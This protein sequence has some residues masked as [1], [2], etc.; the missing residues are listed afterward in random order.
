MATRERGGQPASGIEVVL[1]NSIEGWARFF[2]FFVFIFHRSSL[3]LSLPFFSTHN[4]FFF[5]FSPWYKLAGM[6]KCVNSRQKWIIGRVGGERTVRSS[7]K[8]KFPIRSLSI[9][10]KLKW[11]TFFIIYLDTLYEFGR[12]RIEGRVETRT[13]SCGVNYVDIFGSLS[14]SHVSSSNR[15]IPAHEPEYN[16]RR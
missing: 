1:S 4:V 13:D 15:Q 5:P 12:R 3:F 16:V 10:P 8:P 11:D 6:E 2:R 7:F 14:L 9:L